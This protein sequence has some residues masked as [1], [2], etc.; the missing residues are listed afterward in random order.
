[1]L[2]LGGMTFLVSCLT[3]KD[4]DVTW[5]WLLGRLYIIEKLIAE[6]PTEFLPRQRPDGASSE[7]SLD[8]DLT[9]PRSNVEDELPQNYER[10]LTV[11][12]FAINAVS[13][14]HSR[15]SRVARR[16]FL[17]AARYAAHLENLVEE[18]N[19]LL[20]ELGFTHKKSLKRQLDK[21]VSEFQLSQQVGR[22]LNGCNLIDKDLSPSDSGNVTPASTPKCTSPVTVLSDNQSDS[23]ST[24]GKTHQIVPP[25]IARNSRQSMRAPCRGLLIVGAK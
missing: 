13:N 4:A 18:F 20:N 2:G 6:F 22:E 14:S 11:A 12:D 7:S 10:L 9:G 21:I 19:T 24:A 23:A 15:I 5:Q 1:M 8:F 17:L 16:V 25:D 3:T